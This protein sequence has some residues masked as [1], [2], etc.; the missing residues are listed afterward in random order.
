M[1]IEQ[2]SLSHSHL[3]GSRL[4]VPRATPPSVMTK[5]E[6]GLWA[7]KDLGI[8]IVM[9]VSLHVSTLI[10]RPATITTPWYVEGSAPKLRPTIVTTP[11]QE[12]PRRR[13]LSSADGSKR[14]ISGFRDA[15]WV[16]AEVGGGVLVV[17]AAARVGVTPT[18]AVD[19]AVATDVVEA[20][21][22]GVGVRVAE[23]VDVG[24]AVRV[25]V[26]VGARVGARV[27]ERAGVG[28]VSQESVGAVVGWTGAVAS[29]K[30]LGSPG[31]AFGNPAATFGATT[32]EAS[33]DV[34]DC[35]SAWQVPIRGV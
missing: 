24:V 34:V 10:S 11:P 12:A 19:V 13:E 22:V 7:F 29:T 6:Y 9:R 33:V 35:A 16:G 21:T 5:T 27:G 32:E 30:L 8:E 31:V 18:L 4:Y 17:A 25:G 26:R 1:S 3:P 28:K 23:R 14:S 20:A 15:A 2:P